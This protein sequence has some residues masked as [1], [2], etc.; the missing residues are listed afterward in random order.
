MLRIKKIKPMFTSIVTTGDK[1][2]EDMTEHGFIIAKKGDL[3]LWQKV[4]FIGP[5]VR[6]VEVGNMVMI[7]ADH[8]AVKKYSKESVHNDLDNNPVLTYNF[9][10][11]TIDDS[12]DTPTDCLLLDERDVEYVFEG[13]EQNTNILIPKKELIL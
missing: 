2:T 6:N 10:W 7:N 12:T 4:L 1:F 13:I 8:Y 5:S 3:K 11:V 9:K